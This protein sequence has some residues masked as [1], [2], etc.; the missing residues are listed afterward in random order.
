MTRTTRRDPHAERRDRRQSRDARGR[1]AQ[2]RDARSRGD[3]ERA[4]GRHGPRRD[5]R[6]ERQARR[7]RR[8]ARRAAAAA[9]PGRAAAG[10]SRRAVTVESPDF[11]ILVV[12]DLEG[13]RYSA[14]DRD[15]FG[16]ARQLAD[17]AS[18]SA[19]ADPGSDSQTGAQTGA[20]KGAVVS[21]EFA[22]PRE[23]AEEVGADRVIRP[24]DPRLAGYAPEARAAFLAAV[25]AA[26]APRHVLLPDTPLG[27]GDLGR[28]LAAR[29]GLRASARVW[30]LDP[31]PGDAAAAALTRRG[32]GR[33]VDLIHGVTP[34]LLCEAEIA[35]PVTATRHE[36]RPLDAPGFEVD[37][38]ITD[39]GL[40]P[41]DPDA[42][43]LDEAEFIAGAGAG[44][45]DWEAF[46][47]MAAR[48]GAKKGG[49]RVVVDAGHMPWERQIGASGTVVHPRCYLA[50][51]ISGA[52]QHLQ[53]IE[54]VPHVVAVNIDP[55]CEMM[56]RADLAVVGDVQ[57]I[58]GVLAQKAP[59]AGAQ[60]QAQPE[61]GDESG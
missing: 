19:S 13:G 42:V 3:E 6:A 59:A 24:E 60:A 38:G 61:S 44:V 16:A 12:P 32:G 58:M 54:D 31:Q 27:G 14:H 23:A 22:T 25:L 56:K 41:I 1:D 33:R 5:R 8:D 36:A 7:E 30:R 49:S 46:D 11:L 47:A 17:A 50:L 9:G 28:R 53:G 52:P 55:S 48:L 2:G 29:T 4:A 15:L 39:R 18:A 20:E 10:P 35:E 43:A 51:G 26:H 21:V 45:R 57:D 40:I 37:P 34:I